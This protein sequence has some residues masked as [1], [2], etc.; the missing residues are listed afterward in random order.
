MRGHK[1]S[2]LTDA[3][4]GSTIKVYALDPDCDV[5]GVLVP[6]E[7]TYKVDGKVVP[8]AVF[9]NGSAGEFLDGDRYEVVAP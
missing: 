8:Y 2:R 4:L 6:A 5:T 7:E 1:V 9:Y 3:E